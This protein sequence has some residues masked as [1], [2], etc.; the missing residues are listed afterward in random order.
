MTEKN[1]IGETET[2]TN[3]LHGLHATDRR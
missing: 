1:S 3:R 2:A